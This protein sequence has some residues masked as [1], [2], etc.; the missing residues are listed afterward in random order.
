MAKA[1]CKI[2]KESS[3]RLMQILTGKLILVVEDE[4]YLLS[5]LSDLLQQ[6]GY[7]VV[8]CSTAA[9]AL[10]KVE[11]GSRIDLVMADFRLPDMNGCDL[12]RRLSQRLPNVRFMLT[13]GYSR[14]GY[15][16]NKLKCG[17]LCA[18]RFLQKPY[19]MNEALE[20]VA[21]AL[22]GQKPLFTLPNCPAV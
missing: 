17:E 6:S 20:A 11:E 8:A 13:T 9:E 22:E 5:I 7:S 14:N 1:R 18:H 21:G 12:V 3:G 16:R 10:A 2:Q 15:D 4:P 19:S